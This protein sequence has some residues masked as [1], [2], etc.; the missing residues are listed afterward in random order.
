MAP[1][2]SD[3]IKK[4]QIAFDLLKRRYDDEMGRIKDLDGKAG[5][6]IGFISIVLSIVIGLGTL[7]LFDKLSKPQFYLPYF[8]GIGLLLLSFLF[9][10][11]AIMIAKWPVVPAVEAILRE[12]FYSHPITSRNLVRRISEA[13]ADAIKEIEIK[14]DGKAFKILIGWWLLIA[15]LISIVLFAIIFMTSSGGEGSN[16]I[17]NMT[18]ENLRINNFTLS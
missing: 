2:D 3:E 11:C 17:K 15:G 18:I 5:S 16:I 1:D 14:N 8:I 7:Q 12:G 10:L 13:M 6:Q 9:S 4:G